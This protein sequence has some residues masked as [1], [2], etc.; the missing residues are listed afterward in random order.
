MHLALGVEVQGIGEC[1]GMLFVWD[2]AVQAGVHLQDILSNT[3]LRLADLLTKQFG[4]AEPRVREDVLQMYLALGVEVQG[5]G[6]CLGVLFVGD[7][8]VQAR[9]RYICKTSSRTRGSAWPISSPSSSAKR[10]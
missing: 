7:D 6:E 2:D 10:S 9:A 8:A 5:I 3:G 1:L 4:E